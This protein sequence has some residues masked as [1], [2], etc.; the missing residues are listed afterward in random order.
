MIAAAAFGLPFA[1]LVAAGP[2]RAELTRTDVLVAARAIAFIAK[3][4]SGDL[5][6]GIVVAPES[7][8]SVQDGNQLKTILGTEL[9]VG[10]DQVAGADVELFFLTEGAGADSSKVSGASK[11]AEDTLHHLRSCAGPQWGLHHWCSDSA[12]DRNLRQSQSGGREQHN[13][14]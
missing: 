8:Q 1:L 14:L 5:R 3:A 11:A 12:K 7:A 10:D 9:R 2:A 13:I 6:V 4:G